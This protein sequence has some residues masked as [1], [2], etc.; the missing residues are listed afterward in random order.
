MEEKIT[1]KAQ[2]L[3]TRQATLPGQGAVSLLTRAKR[4]CP[5][6][7]DLTELTSRLQ[8][9]EI[10]APVRSGV[11]AATQLGGKI[12]GTIKGLFS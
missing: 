6:L 2:E 7:I 12:G 1:R 4:E 3:A 5:K 11:E 8:A 9:L 10:L